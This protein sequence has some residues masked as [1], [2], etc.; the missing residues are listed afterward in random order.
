VV[1]VLADYPRRSGR[2]RIAVIAVI[3]DIA[4][5]GFVGRA[6]SGPALHLRE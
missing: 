6:A 3:A 5:I 1:R 2:F 4:L